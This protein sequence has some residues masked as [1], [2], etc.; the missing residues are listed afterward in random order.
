MSVTVDNVA[1]AVPPAPGLDPASDTAPAGD[2]TTSMTTPTIAGTVRPARRSASTSTPS[3]WEQP[4]RTAA[5]S[6]Q[7]RTATLAVGLHAVTASA[8]DTAANLSA[9][10]SSAGTDH[11]RRVDNGTQHANGV[12]RRRKRVGCTQLEHAGRRRQRDHRLPHLPQH[13]QR[14]R[15]PVHERRRHQQLHGHRRRKW[16]DLLLPSRRAEQ[17]RRKCTVD[18]GLGDSGCAR[19]RARHTNG[20]GNGRN[21]IRHGQLDDPVGRR[22]RH[23]RLHHLPRHRERQRNGMDDRRAGRR[24]TSTTTS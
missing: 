23:H 16:N 22:Q 21:R 12:G 2:N 5:G 4:R 13:Q 8:M 11:R 15:N 14:H 10:S 24:A 18:A 1:P 17:C 6:W 3:L 20:D 9:Q 19:H 7:F